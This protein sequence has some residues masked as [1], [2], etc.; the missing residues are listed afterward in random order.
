LSRRLVRL[1]LERHHAFAEL[2][3]LFREQR[4]IDQDAVALH[5]E[6]HVAHRN[7][8]LAVDARELGVD[9]DLRIQRVVQP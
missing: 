7:L 3:A 9:G 1:L 5:L 2:A 8:D 6:Q 4:R